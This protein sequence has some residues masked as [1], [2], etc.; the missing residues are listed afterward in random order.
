MLRL[1]ASSSAD[2][3]ALSSS[4]AGPLASPLLPDGSPFGTGGPVG[5][6]EESLLAGAAA[7]LLSCCKCWG[8]GQL[9][10]EALRT[11]GL[12][13]GCT[14]AAAG[15]ETPL[16]IS[17]GA[18][19]PLS[20][21]PAGLESAEADAACWLPLPC[22]VPSSAAA[23]AASGAVSCLFD[24]L[25]QPCAGAAAGAVNAGA[26]AAPPLA[27]HGAACVSTQLCCRGAS[28]EAL[29]RLVRVWGQ[30]GGEVAS[31][32]LLSCCG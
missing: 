13:T 16:L 14:P 9:C 15:C 21:V 28:A 6:A 22:A 11:T 2:A 32:A 18:L 4:P 27:V 25:A 17:Q 10:R 12:S 19:A 1:L 30:E 20:P 31:S 5:P 7:V 3:A 8:T 26:A 29:G 24:T 23:A